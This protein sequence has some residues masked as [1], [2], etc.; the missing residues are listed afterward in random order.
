M[1]ILSSDI[2]KFHKLYLQTVGISLSDDEARRKLNKLLRQV[3]ILVRE[4]E[5]K[6]KDLDVQQQVEA[7]VSK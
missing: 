7:P 5:K 1:K 4:E 3:E 2:R 6:M